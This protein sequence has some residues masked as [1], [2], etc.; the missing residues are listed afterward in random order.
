MLPAE[1]YEACGLIKHIDYG[2]YPVNWHMH[3]S[4]ERY[5]NVVLSHSTETDRLDMGN[6]VLYKWGR[7][8]AHGAIITQWPLVIHALNGVGVIEQDVTKGRFV[9]R[10]FRAYTLWGDNA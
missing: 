4:E 3:R 7:C 2:N 10:E 9:G 8:F 1:V 5:L 6:F